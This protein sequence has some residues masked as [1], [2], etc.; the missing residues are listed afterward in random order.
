MLSNLMNKVAAVTG[1]SYQQRVRKWLIACFGPSFAD[2]DQER[3]ARHMEE[4]IELFHA[5]GKSFEEVIALAR[6]VYSRPA[7]DPQRELGDV[8]V[9]LA[10]LAEANGHDLVAAGDEALSRNWD[11]VDVIR[12]KQ[13]SKPA[14]TVLPG[15]REPENNWV[16]T[17]TETASACMSYRHDFGLLTPEERRMTIFKAREWLRAWMREMPRTPALRHVEPPK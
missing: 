10:A 9:T 4:S 8:M 16:P 11:R 3:A 14:N 12:E 13:A 17:D 7:G 5:Q 15:A 1:T 6:R 2:P